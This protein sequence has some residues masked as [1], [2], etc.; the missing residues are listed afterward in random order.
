[1]DNFRETAIGLSVW[2]A[3]LAILVG[4]LLIV[5]NH[6]ETPAA[7]LAAADIALL[8]ALGLIAKTRR[9]N[10]H[11]IVHGEFWRA[12]PE[13]ERPRGEGGRRV[14]RITLE[15]TWL[16]F[17]KGAAALAIVLCA[18]AYASHSTSNSAWADAAQAYSSI[19]QRLLPMN[20]SSTSRW[21]G[22]ARC[23][24]T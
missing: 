1:M 5:L 10:E 16:Q 20:D 8:F 3:F 15:V 4:L 24:A 14:A 2:Y 23:S 6:L 22:R 12:L 9:L 17:A 7:F 11:S 18:L 19:D 13:C 21:C